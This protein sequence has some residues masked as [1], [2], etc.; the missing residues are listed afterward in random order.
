MKYRI[1]GVYQGKREVVDEAETETYANYLVGE[2]RLAFGKD[3]SI[4]KEE[5]RDE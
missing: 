3:W 5:T 1:V 4:Y 2:Y